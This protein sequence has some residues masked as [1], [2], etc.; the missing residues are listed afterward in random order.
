MKELP[1]L[2]KWLKFLAWPGL[3]LI[4]AGLVAGGL[5]GWPPLA[6]G[7]VIFGVGLLLLGLSFSGKTAGAFWQQR[8]T[9]V[10]TNAIVSIL[11]LLVILGLINFLG[12]KYSARLDLTE[13]QLYTLAPATKQITQSLD[14]PVRLIIF[15]PIQNPQD[16]QLLESYRRFSDQFSYEYIDPVANPTA[17]QAFEVTQPGSVFLEVGDEI[18]FL[19]TIGNPANPQT[20]GTPETLSERQLTNALERIVSDRTLTIYFVQGHEEYAIEDAASGLS[21]AIGSLE[22]K[23]YVVN[24]LNLTETQAVPEDASVVVV[25]GPAQD[26]FEAEVDAL[27]TY[28][29]AG[30][31]LLLMLDP[32]ADAG[33]NRLLDEWGILLDDSL[34]LDTSGAGQF[35]NLGPAAIIV[36]NYGDHPI[37]QEFGSGRSFFPIARPIETRELPDITSTPL[38]ITDAQSRAE[39]VSDDG[40]LSFDPNAPPNGPYILGA[41]LSRPV[42]AADAAA[43]DTE[44]LDAPSQEARMVVIGNSRFAADGAFEQQLNGDIF[45]NAVSWLGQEGDAALSIRPKTVTDRRILM[46]AQQA[47]GLGLFSLLILPLTGLALAIVMALRRR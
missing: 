25:A 11:A 7:L 41:A 45:L 5:S 20:L 6:I 22:D 27:E 8:S 1:F 21:Q 44:A 35:A 39:S 24:P 15:D 10:G 26:F 43:N 14:Q 38:F 4:T 18:R 42:A 32:R 9:Q 29:D 16:V 13:T 28:L 33:L 40:N 12:V 2:G 23:R 37:T 17:A 36:S 31:G 3:A 46:T 30:G 34:V 19:Q 47:W